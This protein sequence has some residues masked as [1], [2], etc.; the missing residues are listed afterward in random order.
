M[1]I[2]QRFLTSGASEVR[3]RPALL[4]QHFQRMKVSMVTI[5]LLLF[6]ITV[7][8]ETKTHSS[9]RGPFYP[10][11]CCFSYITHAVLP[12][13]IMGYYETNGDC[14]KPAVVFITTKGHRICANPEN[15]WVQDYLKDLEE[16]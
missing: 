2:S 14:P 8:L 16:N 5:S 13:R 11:E 7:T 3:S 4:L 6:L 15:E 12:Y 10:S 9:S 1:I